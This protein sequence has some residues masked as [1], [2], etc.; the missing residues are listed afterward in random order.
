MLWSDL[1]LMRFV[2]LAVAA[3]ACAGLLSACTVRPLEGSGNIS[4]T[5][6]SLSG[7]TFANPDTRQE[8]KLR[9]ALVSLAGGEGAAAEAGA[10][11]RFSAK[12]SKDLV[13][14]VTLRGTGR[15][16]VGRVTLTAVWELIDLQSAS[17]VGAGTLSATSSFDQFTQEFANQEAERDAETR[18]ANELALRLR[19]LILRAKAKAVSSN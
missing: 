19:P 10:T 11:Y 14:A 15:P 6:G 17:A 2:K 13:D 18:A 5:G 12:V 9:N 7:I 4:A 16:A 1:K 8:Q 3:I